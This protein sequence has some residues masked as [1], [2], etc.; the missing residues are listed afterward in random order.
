MKPQVQFL[1]KD[2]I[3][4]IHDASL[5]I[6]STI[7]M[8]FPAKEALEVFEKAGGRIVNSNVVQLDAQLVEKALETVP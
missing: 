6:L 7:G 4:T 3:K 8:R 5:E 1:S 2:E